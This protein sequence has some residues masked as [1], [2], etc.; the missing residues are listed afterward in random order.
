MVVRANK[1]ILAFERISDRLMRIKD[2]GRMLNYN[3]G[4]RIYNS[5]IIIV[6]TAV[7]LGLLVALSLFFMLK[8]DEKDKNIKDEMQTRSALANQLRFTSY[9]DGVVE[10]D[11]TCKY[12]DDGEHIIADNGTPMYRFEGC[13]YTMIFT[14][15]LDWM[16]EMIEEFKGSPI[17]AYNDG[18]YKY[19]DGS[20]FGLW[21]YA[22][23][24]KYVYSIDIEAFKT[25]M[26]GRL[27]SG[28]EVLLVIDDY[29]SSEVYIREIDGK[30]YRMI[31][32]NDSVIMGEYT[33]EDIIGIKEYCSNTI[34]ELTDK[35]K[36]IYMD[37]NNT[38][39]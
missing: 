39:E 18:D 13:K 20:Q 25:Y 33:R 3:G 26:E 38:E 31:I 35:E 7:L 32:A 28:A 19:N 4:R 1:S 8:N 22:S 11:Y 34:I 36:N 24:E 9:K 10:K 2:K 6:V 23:T 17:Q 30:I 5:K 14:Y 21:T 15:R 37:I 12:Y 29:I 27:K 16:Y